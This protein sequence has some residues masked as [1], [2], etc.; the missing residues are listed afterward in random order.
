M[1]ATGGTRRGPQGEWNVYDIFFEA[2]KFDGEKLVK[3]ANVTVVHNGILVQNHKDILGAAIHRKVATYKAHGAEEPL[4]LQD[5]GQPV[6]FRN[7]WIRK[8]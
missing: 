3:P 1:A 7:I 5:H 2:P 4:S 6:R 8:L